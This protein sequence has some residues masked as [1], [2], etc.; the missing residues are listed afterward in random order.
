MSPSLRAIF[1]TRKTVGSWP[2]HPSCVFR[3]ILPERAIGSLSDLVL[4]FPKQPLED[5]LVALGTGF[6]R[7]EPV[8]RFRGAAD[9]CAEFSHRHIVPLVHI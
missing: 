2:G 9:T 7:S 6:E 3:A 1:T 5:F 4:V 8:S